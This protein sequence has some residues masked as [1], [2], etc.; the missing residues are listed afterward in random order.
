MLHCALMRARSGRQ[1]DAVLFDMGGVLLEWDPIRLY[2]RL[3][4]D[5]AAAA[6]LIDEIDLHH[7]NDRVDLGE[8]YDEVIPK[9]QAA[10][11]ERA[12][13]IA[14]YRDRWADTLTGSVPGV[15]EI[16]DTLRAAGVPVSL[17]SNTSAETFPLCRQVAPVLDRLDGIVLSATEGIAKPDRRIYELALDR[18]GLEAA[19]TAFVDD[20]RRNVT[21]AAELGLHAVTFTDAATLR[22]DLRALGLPL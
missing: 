9:W 4:G 13:E 5:P 11:P 22:R 18:F 21:A 2:E 15:A 17:L 8:P 14:A 7:W 16:I 10:H 6:A 3:L 1:V 19:R 20:R 12:E